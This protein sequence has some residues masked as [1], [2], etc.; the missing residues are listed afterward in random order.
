MAVRLRDN[1]DDRDDLVCLAVYHLRYAHAMIAT[2]KQWTIVVFTPVHLNRTLLIAFVVGSWLN[3][4]NH[5]DA[6]LHDPLNA[7]LVAKL[8]LN[9]LTP[10]IVANV[11]LLA[12][13]QH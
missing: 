1:R 8:A 4:F 5:G 7:A 2:I 3:L 10:F 11:G 12:R 6:L 13:H 9:Y